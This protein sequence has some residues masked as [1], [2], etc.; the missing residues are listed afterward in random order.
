MRKYR[1][2]TFFMALTLLLSALPVSVHAAEDPRFDGKTLEEIVSDFME[3]NSIYYEQLSFGYYNTVSGESYYFNGDNLITAASLYKL[4]LNMY[5]SELIYR[6][7][8][9]FD[10]EVC[11]YPYR[12]VQEQSLKYSNNELS[13]GM[14]AQFGTYRDY[15][16]AL[17]PYLGETEETVPSKF[18]SVNEFSAR[19]II[20]C[21]KLLYEEPERFP[22][23]IENM[24]NAGKYK[25]FA[26]HETRYDMANKYGFLHFEIGGAMY[27]INN[28]CAIVY[29]EDPF[30]LTALSCN[31]SAAA[32]TLSELCTLFC[33][34]TNYQ[35]AIRLE[36]EAAKHAAAEDLA[37]S[38]ASAE[39][40]EN[41]LAAEQAAALRLAA[42]EESRAP[43]PQAAV[44]QT[45]AA[46]E[47]PSP[48]PFIPSA[49]LW[50]LLTGI[51]ALAAA[52]VIIR[53]RKAKKRGS[54]DSV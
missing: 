4:P 46:A 45:P 42:L 37:L 25:V 7:E 48:E 40:E 15:R 29:T 52:T 26:L 10:T 19:Q 47:P 54:P 36:E 34:Y 27:R 38:L 14:Q 18:F 5:Y 24:M 6:G 43:E 8:M 50:P 22:G 44:P 3:E 51:L 16:T 39:Q 1:A 20:H 9:T 13:E 2:L 32:G 53:K 30:L 21:L 35:R 31:L 12:V 17:L 23:V 11:G 33:D 41:A 49:I 28:D